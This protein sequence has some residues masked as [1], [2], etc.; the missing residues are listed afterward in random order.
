MGYADVNLVRSR[1]A[2]AG[3]LAAIT[4]MHL[5]D[6]KLCNVAMLP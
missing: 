1:R 5:R 6:K 4:A 2:G 3:R